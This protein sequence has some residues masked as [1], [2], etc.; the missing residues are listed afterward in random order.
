MVCVLDQCFQRVPGLYQSQ[1][2][3][4]GL[5]IRIHHESEGGIEKSVLRIT[6]LSS[7]DKR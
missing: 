2:I 6:G 3:Y 5:I 1:A 7:D 4:K